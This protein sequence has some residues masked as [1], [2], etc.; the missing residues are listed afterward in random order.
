MSLERE[1][2]GRNDV[3]TLDVI[4][5]HETG[6]VVVSNVVPT[7]FVGVES[8]DKTRFKVIA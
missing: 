8:F 4:T 7:Y 1:S 2:G 3:L 6:I 5:H